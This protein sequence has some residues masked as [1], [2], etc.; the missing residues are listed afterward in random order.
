MYIILCMYICT[1]VYMYIKFYLILI[2]VVN[3]INDVKWTRLSKNHIQFNCTLACRSAVNGCV[4]EINGTM[5]RSTDIVKSWFNSWAIVDFYSLDDDQ[6]F[7]YAVYAQ[8]N[9]R[10]ILGERIHGNIQLVCIQH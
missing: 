3:Y 4:V 6:A 1:Q 2:I 10:N 5:N 9:E 7:P 8:D